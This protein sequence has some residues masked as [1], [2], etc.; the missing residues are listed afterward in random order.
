M[1]I[2]EKGTNMNITAEIKDYLYKKLAYLEKFLSKKDE[3]V[4]CDVE[5][6]MISRHHKSGDVFRAEINLQ[7]PGKSLRAEAEMGDIYAAIDIAKD[8]MVR[9]LQVTKDKK[10][11]KV[12]RGGAKVKNITK[13]LSIKN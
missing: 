12:R 1:R 4:M 11:S 3:S 10:V 6:G 9:E 8:E 7:M 13:N 2:N 5:L